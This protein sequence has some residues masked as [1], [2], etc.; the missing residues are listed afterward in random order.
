MTIHVQ[1]HLSDK[2][3]RDSVP[4]VSSKTG[5]MDTHNLCPNSR[6]PEVK[7]VLCINHTACINKMGTEGHSF[8]RQGMVGTEI[9]A[10]KYQPRD[11][12]ANSAF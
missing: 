8:V 10:S 9:Q 4:K 7:Q 12:S 11:N 3:L 2:L 1:N 6:L 5:H